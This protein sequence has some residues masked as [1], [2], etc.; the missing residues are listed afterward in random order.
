MAKIFWAVK[1]PANKGHELQGILK[2]DG[3]IELGV[4]AWRTLNKHDT[5]SHEIRH[6]RSILDVKQ[7]YNIVPIHKGHFYMTSASEE[8]EINELKEEENEWTAIMN[9]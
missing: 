6:Y 3:T 7:T 9:C 5:N 1:K 8:N 4:D 2:N